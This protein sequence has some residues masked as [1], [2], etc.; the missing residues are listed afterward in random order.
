MG[1]ITTIKKPNFFTPEHLY[2][3]DCSMKYNLQYEMY[4]VRFRMSNLANRQLL[5]NRLY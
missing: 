1:A 5:Q 4:G 2:I 3:P